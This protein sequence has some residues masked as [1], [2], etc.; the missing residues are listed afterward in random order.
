MFEESNDEERISTFNLSEMNY[1]T[2]RYH[3]VSYIDV[4]YLFWYPSTVKSLLK[5]QG[6]KP[7]ATATSS[8]HLQPRCYTL[9]A[10]DVAQPT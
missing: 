1:L 4:V 9:F 5:L 3:Q 10:T 6:G 7:H 8:V 2:E